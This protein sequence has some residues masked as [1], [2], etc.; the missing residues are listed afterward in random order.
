MAI[1]SLAEAKDY[2]RVSQDE[3][4]AV[5]QRLVNQ[6]QSHIESLLGYSIASTFGGTGQDPI[7]PA[8]G[9]AV[10][11]LALW[12]YDNRGMASEDAR[13][14]PFGVREIINEHRDWTF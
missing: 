7:P 3:D 6:A 11:Q 4:D 10:C 13:E 9:E 8:L 2:M 1:V 14:A 5:I 12:W